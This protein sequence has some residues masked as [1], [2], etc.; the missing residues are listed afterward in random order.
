VFRAA[1]RREFRL[2]ELASWQS[3]LVAVID[4]R[5]LLSADDGYELR[6]GAAAG[7]IAAA[8]AAL[9][10]VFPADLRQVYL[11]SD[12]VFDRTGQWFVIWPLPEVVTRNR[13][14]WSQAASPARCQLVGFGDDGTGAPFC[15]P[16]DGSSGVFAWSAIDGAATLLASSVAGFWSGWVAS[17]LP[18]H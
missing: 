2:P 3:G 11:A 6:P 16:R 17:T 5:Q 9:G 1:G 4:W 18:P 8:E 15:V 7:E 13:A 14:A 10:A 12:G